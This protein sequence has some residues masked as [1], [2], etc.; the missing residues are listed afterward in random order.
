[1]AKKVPRPREGKYLGMKI[2]NSTWPDGSW[3]EGEEFCYPG[4]GFTRF[5]WAELG[6]TG[7]HVKVRASVPDTYFSIPAKAANGDHGFLSSDEKRLK[8]TVTSTRESRK[9]AKS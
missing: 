4:G 2:V 1:M 8:F 3:L 5:A 9:A 6:E 7:E